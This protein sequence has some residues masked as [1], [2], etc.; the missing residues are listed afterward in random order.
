MP[1]DVTGLTQQIE[2]LTQKVTDSETKCAKL[3]EACRDKDLKLDL[4]EAEV[5]LLGLS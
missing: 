2:E 4:L 5:C 3:A 1:S